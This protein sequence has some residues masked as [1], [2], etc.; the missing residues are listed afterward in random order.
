MAGTNTRKISQLTTTGQITAADEFE[1]Y[2]PVT[3]GDNS[4]SVT[5]QTLAAY[6]RGTINAANFVP[7]QPD[8]NERSG[9]FLS[10]DLTWKTPV[11][12][13]GGTGADTGLQIVAKLTNLS[14]TDRLSY[15][16]LRNLPP[17]L[18][19]VSAANNGQFLSVVNGAYGL[20]PA[21]SG[22]GTAPN[23]TNLSAILGVEIPNTITTIHPSW[24]PT[25]AQDKVTGLPA[26]VTA[27]TGNT[28]G[29]AANLA[30]IRMLQLSSGV[31]Q[32]AAVRAYHAG[33]LEAHLNGAVQY[34]DP[35][36]SL[37]RLTPDGA[38]V[39]NTSLDDDFV[40]YIAASAPG[41]AAGRRG[42]R[43]LGVQDDKVT[44]V[45]L[46]NPTEHALYIPASSGGAQAWYGIE[47]D[48]SNNRWHTFFDPDENVG[49]TAGRRRCATSE[50]DVPYITGDLVGYDVGARTNSQL[51]VVPVIFRA[52]GGN[53]I[54]CNTI[55]F[56]SQ[57]AVTHFDANTL[58]IHTGDFVDDIWVGRHS[59][60]IHHSQI[61]HAKPAVLPGL[62]LRYEG[63][64][65]DVLTQSVK[66]NYSA[67]LQSEGNDV[68]TA[69][70]VADWAEEGNTDPIPMAKLVNAGA[71]VTYPIEA[72]VQVAHGASATT[73]S[74]I[75]GGV[76]DDS[77]QEFSTKPTALPRHSF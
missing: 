42:I 14:G 3:S 61:A 75:S 24:L 32:T 33:L 23:A 25:L 15:T 16:A 63:T 77:L 10:A 58:Y 34:L 53:P 38:G 20:V 52:A 76:W 66:V 30:A 62:G 57:N 46:S 64:G 72:Y 17:T 5:A 73:L 37:V 22:G 6:V 69:G 9:K 1:I 59:G 60:Y 21:P 13:G 70:D 11:T 67:G 54:Q 7:D 26:V 45:K 12:S 50:G 2:R 28:A 43:G 29:V 55:E 56:N 18:P 39:I 4:L 49:L 36:I 47:T 48:A 51:W 65:L 68:L 19:A 40:T 44:Y 74:L 35:F 41:N 27:V 8:V 71:S 31:Q